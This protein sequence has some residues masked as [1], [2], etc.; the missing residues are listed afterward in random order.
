MTELLIKGVTLVTG[1]P[2]TDSGS[3]DGSS[4]AALAAGGQ[5]LLIKDGRYADPAEASADAAVIDADGLTAI[6]GLIDLHTHLREPGREDAE[7]V[8][9][10]TQAAARGGFAA[11][12]AMANTNPVTEI[13]A[14]VIEDRK[15]RADSGPPG[16]SS[17]VSALGSSC[18]SP[19]AST[20]ASS[21][22]PAGTSQ[23]VCRLRSRR[24]VTDTS[25][26]AGHRPGL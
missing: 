6:P 15:L 20:N 21:T 26:T 18:G 8:D 22:Q 9:T 7:T 11:V 3:S 23:N 14:V 24:W 10:G 2:A 17:E 25:R 16:N 5:D 13:I 4:G 12:L 1:S 19:R